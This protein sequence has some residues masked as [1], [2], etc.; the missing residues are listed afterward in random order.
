MTF[1]GSCLELAA[2]RDNGRDDEQ[3]H[4]VI[5]D[6]LVDGFGSHESCGRIGEE[7]GN[8]PPVTR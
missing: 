1:W 7:I 2:P 5:L 4:E 8:S 6:D 3:D